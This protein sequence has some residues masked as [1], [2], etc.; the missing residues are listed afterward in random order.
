MDK[1]Q[2]DEVLMNALYLLGGTSTPFKD[3]TFFEEIFDISEEIENKTLRLLDIRTDDI[4]IDDYDDDYDDDVVIPDM[5]D[6]IKDIQSKIDV[7]KIVKDVM[8]KISDNTILNDTLSPGILDTPIILLDPDI[9]KDLDVNKYNVTLNTFKKLSDSDLL[10]IEKLKKEIEEINNN[11]LDMVSS[12]FK[13]KS[14]INNK[15]IQKYKKIEALYDMI[16]D[17]KTEE[18]ENTMNEF[19]KYIISSK[20]CEN[21]PSVITLIASS[22]ICIRN[23]IVK[24]LDDIFTPIINKASR[25]T[26]ILLLLLDL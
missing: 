16:C 15:H 7:D 21:K 6:L 19:C 20:Y 4:Y 2:F 25:D 22:T 1:N 26:D 18:I 12:Q 13:D 14:L 17:K 8:K 9:Y 23:Y 11:M 10:A 5:D 24:C 3:I